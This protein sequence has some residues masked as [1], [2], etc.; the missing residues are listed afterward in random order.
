MNVGWLELLSAWSWEPPIVVGL[1]AAAL[2]YGLGWCRLAGQRRGARALPVWRVW[3]YSGGLLFMALAMLSPVEAFGEDLLLMHMLQH[4]LLLSAAPLI[5]LGWPILPVLWALPRGW[6]RP[7]GLLMFP[8]G[9]LWAFFNALTH[10][11]VAITVYVLVVGVWH[12]P[13]F[14]NAAE[15]ETLIHYVE[16]L[17]F[18]GGALLYWWPVVHPFGGRR[19]LGFGTAIFYLAP[20]LVE[21]NAIGMVLT[22]ADHPLYE[23]YAHGHGLWDISPVFDQQLAGGAMGLIGAFIHIIA[24]SAIL[25]L[26]LRVE[27]AS[28]LKAEAAADSVLASGI[29]RG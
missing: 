11:A 16:H 10:P 17:S 20:G 29:D 12:V 4:M 21:Q 1:L 25:V 8:R 23:H 19:R 6:R 5:L 28:S 24:I 15:G 14:Y 13:E 7:V 27:E 18:L 26:F 9:P 22:F 2:L 3:A